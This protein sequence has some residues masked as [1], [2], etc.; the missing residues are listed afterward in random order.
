LVGFFYWGKLKNKRENI[1]GVFYL[2][3]SI[4]LEYAFS[5]LLLIALEGLLAADNP[6]VKN[7]EE[8]QAALGM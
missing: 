7:N 5:L 6:P 1:N 3:F 8:L 2:E 4:L